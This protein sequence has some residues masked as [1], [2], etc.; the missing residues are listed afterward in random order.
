VLKKITSI[1]NSTFR[2]IKL[3]V[4]EA[5]WR[6]L[7]NHPGSV[8]DSVSDLPVL[9]PNKYATNIEHYEKRLT[10]LLIN[11]PDVNEVAI[12]A[13]YAGGK[14]SFIE[15]YK[16]KNPQL[17]SI[18]ISLADFNESEKG[19]DND[20]AES[21]NKLNRIEKSILQQLLYSVKDKILPNSRFRKITM[22]KKKTKDL[23]AHGFGL[24]LFFFFIAILFFSDLLLKLELVNVFLIQVNTS[25]ATISALGVIGIGSLII[26]DIIKFFQSHSINKVNLLKGEVG[27]G[28]KSNDSIFNKHLEEIIYFFHKTKRTVVIFEDI[29][30]LD[31]NKALFVKLKELNC[32]LNQSDDI[33]QRVIFIY[34]IKDDVFTGSDR[35]KFF[36][37][38][39]PIVPIT[40]TVNVYPTLKKLIQTSYVSGDLNDDDLSD[41]YLRDISPF[42]LDM[43][44]LKNIVAEYGIY[45]DTLLSKNSNLIK[46]RLFSFIV[47][48]N[49]YADDFSL[50]HH[51]EGL[52]LQT[53]GSKAAYLEQFKVQLRIEIK[54]YKARIELSKK[55]Q[56]KSIE[57]LNAIFLHHLLKKIPHIP[58]MIN[59][60]DVKNIT[61]PLIFKELYA[62]T[63]QI[64][65][66]FNVNHYNNTSTTME[67]VKSDFIPSFL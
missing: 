5:C 45:R 16:R 23:F 47:Y 24:A 25:L 35:T 3:F 15:T 54:D 4:L 41:T 33:S 7:K 51:G 17:N 57:E 38:I 66:R 64:N 19:N 67:V 21:S 26:T 22:Q 43:R 48:K 29:D 12:T 50:L 32:L 59:D 40:N 65:Y 52:F 36:D 31:N 61:A 27:F 46:E 58:T 42:I 30:R 56:L 34:C 9:T 8:D 62:S 11:E 63:G 18:S 53:L 39:I 1:K 37:S 20:T 28:E 6:I 44:L 49:V 10:H 14:S 13:P 60:I 55:E 2:S